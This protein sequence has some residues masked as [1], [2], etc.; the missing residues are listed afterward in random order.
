MRKYLASCSIGLVLICMFTLRAVAED[1]PANPDG[2]VNF[3]KSIKRIFE[4]K[5]IAG[6]EK[7]VYDK[8]GDESLRSL[9]VA[10]LKVMKEK[11]VELNVKSEVMELHEYDPTKQLHASKLKL[12]SPPAKW[13]KVAFKSRSAKDEDVIEFHGELVFPVAQID[14]RWM[15]I[16][17]KHE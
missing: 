13:V 14:G 7:I 1:T 9:V 6:F 2:V 11:D 16:G 17:Y 4:T 5:D 15:I 12:I 10:Y 8:N 3:S